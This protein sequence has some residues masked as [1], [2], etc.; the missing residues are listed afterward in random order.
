[1]P[2]TSL[3]LGFVLLPA[4]LCMGATL[5]SGEGWLDWRRP[6]ENPVFTTEHGNN[7][8][9]I[10]FVE[11]ALAYP[12]HLIV[13]HTPEAAHLWRAKRF[14]WRSSDWELVSRDYQ[15]GGH[16]EYDDG[17]VVD[18][19]YYI[20]EQGFV[21]T[22]A[23]PLESASGQWKKAG[24]FPKDQCDDVGVFYEGEVFH[25]FGEH[26]DF[27]HGPDG[28]SLAHFT[29]PT[30]LGDWTLVNAKA[31]DPNPDGGDTHGV[32]DATLAKIGGAYYLYCDRETKELPYRVTA[33]TS[34]SLYDPFRYLG[35]AMA[36]RSGETAHWDNHRIQD[37][38]IAYAPEL[39]H[40]VMVCNMK[41][42]DGIPGGKFPTLKPNET[43]VIG[44]FYSRA[45]GEGEAGF[46]APEPSAG[47]AAPWVRHTIDDSSLGADGVRLAD[48]DGD[49]L[50]DI[51]TAWEE[52]GEIRVYCRPGPGE[53]R[54]PWPRVTVGRVASPEDAVF[55]DLDGDGAADVISSCEGSERSV[56]VHWAPAPGQ[57]YM[58]PAAWRTESFPQL[59]GKAQWMYC[60]P[61]DADG[62]G[63]TD[64][65]LGAK[66]R[67]AV[68]GWLACPPEPRDLA[69][70]TWQVIYEAGW[71]MSMEWH[72]A[73]PDGKP[74]ILVSD[75]RGAGRG[76]LWLRRT[77]PGG[78]WNVERIGP[79]GEAEVMF[80]WGGRLEAGG[81]FHVAVGA[82]RERLL[83]HFV[84]GAGTEWEVHHAPAPPAVGVPKGVAAADLNED[85]RM[86]LV[87]SCEE[88][89]D[90]LG[91][92]ALDLDTLEMAWDIA[93][94]TGT[95]FDDVVTIDMD[96]DADVDV[97]TC[98]EREALGVV[99]YEN[100]L[101][102][103]GR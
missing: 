8:D 39:G 60:L 100:P 34:P 101:R 94:K 3:R 102:A 76:V 73:G 4:L 93:G 30:G 14:S 61:V 79:V 28:T 43:R 27:P 5:G 81:P 11:P 32:G 31:V 12:Y 46:G 55:A 7:H 26:G 90:R 9:A 45:R 56:N 13:S 1:M 59:R 67:G 62:D 15:I 57:D 83:F 40:Y 33:W 24:V 64:L 86:E 50:R 21:Y 44:T 87:L 80:L 49:G 53:V 52:G 99:W 36:P 6:A 20:Y 22:H 85:G 58:N 74:G 82:K 88:A 98:E 54:Q 95:K 23:G 38:D 17:V 19:V 70:W 66:N 48:V 35:V 96:G 91:L 84:Q 72:G 69:A 2:I 10:L 103:P 51:T 75:R 77:S 92:V 89:Q 18:G 25:L 16:Y 63:D 78:G 97:L 37:A 29:S 65:V 71:I 42:T 68:V 47:A 41:D